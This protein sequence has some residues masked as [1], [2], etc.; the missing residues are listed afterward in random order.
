MRELFH[1]AALGMFSFL[2]DAEG[3]VG[4]EKHLVEVTADNQEELLV[5]WLRK[6]LSLHQT[7]LLIPTEIDIE[8]I[9]E[10]NIKARVSCLRVEEGDQ[11]IFGEIK[12]VTYHGLEISETD[13]GLVAQIVFDT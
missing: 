3:L 12:A 1:N 4:N 10:Q 2:V 11:R 5:S 8:S 9:S 7:E 13:D 6:L